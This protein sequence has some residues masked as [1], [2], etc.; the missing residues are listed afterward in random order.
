MPAPAPGPGLIGKTV[1]HYMTRDGGPPNK[2]APPAAPAAPAPPPAYCFMPQGAAPPAQPGPFMVPPG[3]GFPG[4]VCV[5][6]GPPSAAPPAPPGYWAIPPQAPPAALGWWCPPPPAAAPPAPPPPPSWWQHPPP[7]PPAAAAPPAPPAP[8][9][10]PPTAPGAVAQ[11][12]AKA[13]EPPVSGNRVKENLIVVKDS[14]GHGHVVSKHNATFH[15][16]THDVLQR[17]A[18]NA[19]NQFYIPPNACE[20]FRVMTASYSMPIEEFIEQLDCIK[21]APPNWP[22][23]NIGIAEAFDLGNG[24]F[25]VGSKFFLDEPK[26]KQTIKEAWSMSI[27]EANES[28]PKYLIRIPG[29]APG[30]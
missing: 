18:T 17:Y 14:G 15:L 7:A 3:P 29:K 19:N 10:P 2:G 30:T 1:Y 25:Q 12:A 9:V 20:E 28:R 27:G 8:P 4:A 16:F 24:W 6:N 22:R 23:Y 11:A 26:S 13:P 5:P 21:I